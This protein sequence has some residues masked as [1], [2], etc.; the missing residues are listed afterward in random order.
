[1]SDLF[2]QPAVAFHAKDDLPKVRFRVFDLLR[3]CGDQLRFYA[4]VCDKLKL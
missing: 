2:N 4:V 3:Q 1:M